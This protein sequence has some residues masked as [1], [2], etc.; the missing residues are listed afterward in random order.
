[1]LRENLFETDRSAGAAI[2]DL[3]SEKG[4]VIEPLLVAQPIPKG[5]PTLKSYATGLKSGQETKYASQDLHD[6][7][8]NAVDSLV[9]NIDLTPVQITETSVMRDSRYPD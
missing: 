7:G 3:D 1:M 2:R 8:L 6:L 5:T 9:P 4:F